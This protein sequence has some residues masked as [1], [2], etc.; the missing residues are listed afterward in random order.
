MSGLWT[1]FVNYIRG[2][3]TPVRFV[4]IAAFAIV[5]LLFLKTFMNKNVQK[6]KLKIGSVI[7][8]IICLVGIALLIK[9]C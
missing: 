3:S 4:L 2:I 7:L 8:S 9:Y 5:C 6:D 1:D